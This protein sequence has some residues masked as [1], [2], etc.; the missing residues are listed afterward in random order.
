[1]I[2]QF[3]KWLE[4]VPLLDWNSERASYAFL[5]RVFS[6]FGAPTEVLSNQGTK[7]HREFQELCEKALINHRMTSRNHLEVNGLIE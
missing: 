2:E 1:M 3:S 6:R 7:F 4:F 5:D